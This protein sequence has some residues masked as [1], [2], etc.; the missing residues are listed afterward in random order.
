M[1][2]TT[3]N[4]EKLL[5]EGSVEDLMSINEDTSFTIPEQRISVPPSYAYSTHEIIIPEEEAVTGFHELF[6][7]PNLIELSSTDIIRILEILKK[8]NQR[9]FAYTYY[10]V[11]KF[12]KDVRQW[13][14]DNLKP[15][16]D[17]PYYISD[18][19]NY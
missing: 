13:V 8:N 3:K 19:E 1:D 4:I 11:L 5:R 6:R 15:E 7:N 10:D 14:I 17:N 9:F 16:S 12:D 18:D 2:A